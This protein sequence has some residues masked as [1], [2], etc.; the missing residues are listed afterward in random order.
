MIQVIRGS[1]A[2]QLVGVSEFDN[3][4]ARIYAGSFLKTP[5]DVQ[6]LVV[7]VVDGTPVYVRDLADVSWANAEAD[8]YVN[9]Y[10]GPAYAGATGRGQARRW[11]PGRHRRDREEAG[12]QRGHGRQ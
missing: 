4:Q 10:T 3:N 1:N 7:R 5:R 6:N 2:D 12:F 9:H 8:N 11:R